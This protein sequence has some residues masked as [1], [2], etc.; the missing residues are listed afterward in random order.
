VHR[1]NLHGFRDREWRAEAPAGATRVAFVGDSF[2]EGF[3]AA[4]PDTLPARFAEL[5]ARGGRRADV[6][7]LGVGGAGL[8]AYAKLLRDALPLWRPDAAIL[9]LYANDVVPQRFDPAWL[10][11]ALAPARA[12]AWTP[13]LLHVLRERAAGRAVPRR[14][15]AAPFAFL[16]AAPDP[17]NPWTDG[18]RAGRLAA[19]VAPDLARAIRE[20]RFNPALTDFLAW[21]RTSLARDV[22]LDAQLAPLATYAEGAGAR[23]HVVYVPTKNQVSDRYLEFQARY[24]RPED[25]RSLLAPEYQRHAARLRESCASLDLPFLDLTPALR[26]AEAARGPLYWDYDDHLRP[27]GYAL[28]AEQVY[29]WWAA[30]PTSTR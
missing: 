7:N 18:R 19:F 23:L 25:V 17:R 29:A 6:L 20:G 1:L 8:P 27:A 26:E 16:P 5:A 15:H 24:T 11:G 9:V 28:A 22:A 14:W 21:F 13:R 12:S 2:V 4:A 3:S 30:G 10:E